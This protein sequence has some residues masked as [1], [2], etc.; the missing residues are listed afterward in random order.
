M[1]NRTN[2]LI[3]LFTILSCSSSGQEQVPVK[4]P[5]PSVLGSQPGA[6]PK[7]FFYP[8]GEKEIYIDENGKEVKISDI[9]PEPFRAISTNPMEAFRVIMSSDGYSVRQ[10]RGGSHMRRKP[11]LEGDK[12]IIEDINQFNKVNMV[13]DG[14]M[15]VKLNSKTGKL[16]NVNFYKR[17]PRIHDLAKI[18]QNDV[19]RWVLEHKSEE[20]VMT[21]FL[22]T[23]YI[24]LQKK[25]SKEEPKAK[26]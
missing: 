26:Q 24:V 21:K 23:Y 6:E 17:I 13:D 5:A 8:A 18:M 2:I 4:Q 19:T 3:L 15:I 14:L 1:R 10:I 7:Q 11:D 20:P 12:V 16:E 22:V 9:D 25:Q